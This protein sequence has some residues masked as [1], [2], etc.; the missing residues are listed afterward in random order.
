MCP[1]ADRDLVESMGCN[2]WD[3]DCEPVNK[4]FNEKC[5]TYDLCSEKA[6]FVCQQKQCVSH[7]ETRNCKLADQC[8]DLSH[9]HLCSNGLCHN[10]SN[11][12]NCSYTITGE[13]FDCRDK[14]NCITITGL[15][16]CNKGLC[17]EVI[18]PWDCKRKCPLTPPPQGGVIIVSG[19]RTVTAKCKKVR[20]ATNGNSVSWGRNHSQTNL[21]VSCTDVFTFQGNKSSFIRGLDCVNGT[22][23]D[24]SV[25]PWDWEYIRSTLSY[26]AYV[27]EMPEIPHSS[28]LTIFNKTKVNDK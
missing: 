14:R 16:N 25:D 24:L 10:V 26:D 7:R 4:R 8:V 21:L 18:W 9:Q 27:K 22:L 20:V 6:P 23:F 19:D 11:V 28:S 1:V 17:T 3:D 12:M 15:F 2:D 5:S 13:T